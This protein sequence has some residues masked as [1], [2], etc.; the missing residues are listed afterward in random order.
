MKLWKRVVSILLVVLLLAGMMPSSL[1]VVKADDDYWDPS[2]INIPISLDGT[3]ETRGTAMADTLNY[4]NH[5]VVEWK[6]PNS[7]NELKKLLESTKDE[8]TYICLTKKIDKTWT[9]SMRDTVEITEDKV[10]DLNGYTIDLHVDTN[11]HHWSY[12]G[13]DQSPYHEDS[14]KWYMNTGFDITDGAS[15]YILDSSTRNS[16]NGK[17][18]TGK[19]YI[20]G[21]MLDPFKN[22][23]WYG[24]KDHEVNYYASFD[25]FSVSNGNLII[26]GGN[27][28]AGRSKANMESNWSWDKLK[29]VIGQAVELGSS[30]A[31]YA[32]GISASV[33]AKSDVIESFDKIKK[34]EEKEPKDT[35]NEKKEEKTKDPDNKETTKTIG[36]K[37]DGIDKKASS[38]PDHTQNSSANGEQKANENG[39]AKADKD[40]E[41]GKNTKIAEANKKITDS[42][43]NQEGISDIV[44]KTYDFVKGI[45]SMTGS[46]H[47]SLVIQT[48][49]GTCVRLGSMGTFVSYGGN[50]EGYG[51]SPNTRNAVVESNVNGSKAYIYGGTFK[52]CAGANVFNMVEAL[53][54]AGNGKV[55]QVEYDKNGN[56]TYKDV[57]I[58][59]SETM[60]L[61]EVKYKADGD[62]VDT[63]SILVRGGTFK[64]YYEAKNVGIRTASDKHFSM[65]AGTSGSVNLGLG[66]FGEDFI[67]DGRIQIDDIYGNGALVL[68]DENSGKD[69]DLYHYRLLC[70]DMELRYKQ[71]LRVY[72]NTAKTNSSNSFSLKTQYEDG[73]T[74]SLMKV[75]ADDE[76]NLRGAYSTTEKVFFYPINSS[77]SK[78]YTIRPYF[79]D[80][81]PEEDNLS[82]S[83][84]W[85]YPDPLDTEGDPIEPLTLTDSFISGTLKSSATADYMSNDP[86]VVT[87]SFNSSLNTT[88]SSFGGKTY[89]D[90]R[91]VRDT[92]AKN[93]NKVFDNYDIAFQSYQYVS[94]L[95]W[96]EYKVYKVDPLTRLNISAG[97][98]GDDQPL[99][100]GT[101]GADARTGLKTM[102]RLTDLEDQIK[103]HNPYWKGFKQGEM[104]RITLS[105]EERLNTD[106]DGYD[107]HYENTTRNNYDE[108]YF[109]NS[110]GTAK[111]NTSILFMCYGPEEQVVVEDHNTQLE[112]FTP[113]QWNSKN[114]PAGQ[115]AC[116]EFVNAK[117]GNVDYSPNTRIFDIYYQW[118][119]LDEDGEK[120]QLIAGT[121][122]VWDIRE[123]YAQAKEQN[124]NSE[125]TKALLNTGKQ[126]HTL[127]SWLRGKDGFQYA[128]TIAPW[129]TD[130]LEAVDRDGNKIDYGDDGLPVI[131]YTASGQ[132]SPGT[133]KWPADLDKASRLIH[134][135][136]TAWM[137]PDYLKLWKDNN[138][139]NQ[140]NNQDYGQYDYCY[141]PTD[142][143][144][145]QIIVEA[146]AVNVNWTDYYDAMQTFYSHPITVGA[147]VPPEE[148]LQ[149]ASTIVTF[150]EKGNYASLLNEAEISIGEMTDLIP[151]EYVKSVYFKAENEEGLKWATNSSGGIEFT[152]AE[153][154]QLPTVKFPTDFLGVTKGAYKSG[155]D[156]G[157]Y[158]FSALVTTNM[159]R[160]VWTTPKDARYEVEAER[161]LPVKDSYTFDIE[162]LKSGKYQS[163]D[164]QLFKVY[165]T[166][167][168]CGLYYDEATTTNEDVAYVDEKGMLGFGGSAGEATLS[169]TGLDGKTSNIQVTVIDYVDNVDISNINP[170]EIG[171]TLPTNVMIPENA[172]YHVERVYW[173]NGAGE[174]L[175]PSYKARNYK[176]Y[177][178]NI[179]I[180]KNDPILVFRDYDNWHYTSFHPYELHVNTVDGDGVTVT[181][182]YANAQFS[183]SENAVNGYYEVGDS[184]TYS[185]TY[186]DAI[187]GA[188]QIIDTV[189][190]DF[191]TEAEE[192][193]SVDTWMESFNTSTNGDDTEFT[194]D[195]G[196]AFTTF[197]KQTFEAY[198][199]NVD[200]EDPA[201]T[202]KSFVKGTIV[203]P[204]VTVDLD[205][206]GDNVSVAFEDD[207]DITVN[208]NGEPDEDA[209][210]FWRGDKI[211]RFEVPDGLTILEGQSIPVSPEYQVRD[212]NIVVD[213][214]LKLDDLLITDSDIIRLVCDTSQFDDEL[215]QYLEY[216]EN[217][218]VLTGVK[219]SGK[220]LNIPLYVIVDEDGDG[221]AEMRHNENRSKQIY[222]SKSACPELD[223]GYDINVDVTVLKPDGSIAYN[224]FVKAHKWNK[225]AQWAW[226][227][228]PEEAYTGAFI[229]DVKR[230]NRPDGAFS[231]NT[232]S[233]A[234][235]ISATLADG[236]TLTVYTTDA[237]E[238]SV[239]TSPTEIYP[240][241]EGVDDLCV[242]LDGDH[243][244]KSKVALT[245][246]TPDTEYLL[247]YR[248]GVTDTFYTK[249]VRTDP[250]GEE[251]GI[252]VGRKPVTPSNPGNL[253]R[254]HYHYDAKSNTLTIKDLTIEDMGVD[255]ADGE[256]ITEINGKTF[257]WYRYRAQSV[258]YAK[259]D[260]TIELQGDNFLNK[261]GGESEAFDS[262]N[263]FSEGSITFTGDGNITLEGAMY[264]IRPGDGKH[265]FLKGSGKQVITGACAYYT[266]DGGRVYY[267]NGD[268]DFNRG[269]ISSNIVRKEDDFVVTNAVHS[270]KY[271]A[272][273]NE[274]V[275]LSHA[276][277]TSDDY[278][279]IKEHYDGDYNSVDYMHVIPQHDFSK[280]VASE[281]YF[282]SESKDCTKGATYYKS[283]SC[284]AADTEHTF[285]V[286][287]TGKHE[288]IHHEGK[289]P[290]CIEE[291]YKAYD[292]CAKC[293]YTTFEALPAAG[294]SYIHHDEV[295]PTCETDGCPAYDICSVCGYTSLDRDIQASIGILPMADEDTVKREDLW[296]ATG[297]DLVYVP[298]VASTCTKN[299]T[300]DYYKCVTCGDIYADEFGLTPISNSDLVI[301]AGHSMTYVE[302][303]AATA[304]EAGNDEYYICDLCGKWFDDPD[305]KHEIKDHDSV[306][307]PAGETQTVKISKT[308][309]TLAVG[310]TLT[311]TAT[312]GKVKS[313]T[314]DDEKIATVTSEGKVTAVATGTAV[315]TAKFSGGRIASCKIT[316]VK[317]SAT[318]AT[319]KAGKTKTLKVTGATVKSWA[320]SKKTVATVTKSG[321]VTALT[322]GS[323]TITATLN[324]GTK[325][326][327]KITVSSNPTLKI[328]SK[329]YKSSTTYTVKKGKTLTV[330]IT[331]KASSVKNVYSTTKKTIA[332]V[333]SKATATKVKIKGLKKG[334]ATVTIK[335]NGKAFKIKVKVN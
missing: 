300:K 16:V 319:L 329:A 237:A 213:E 103:A 181:N 194:F 85:Y 170:P 111:A 328:G 86:S 262:Y 145:K 142:L 244:T 229:T 282:V 131:T 267:T 30:V 79:K 59:P 133:N 10:L 259:G 182:S 278:Q 141:I 179:E 238:V 70:S 310:K 290:T 195:K 129:D 69:G 163:G 168:S 220:A 152:V 37:Q 18:G 143:A 295:A 72:P 49:F 198:G 6:H 289:A 212:F 255:V 60:N 47:D 317:I 80:T 128:N 153:G 288:L 222:A 40:K 303:K 81:N 312:G 92:S 13:V 94:N 240:E 206:E 230:N 54:T 321:K 201:D 291:G 105:V 38:D 113:L 146:I 102:I 217:K 294:H 98:L 84:T 249:V 327:C 48:H 335:V 104:Y 144:G 205:P 178:I 95:K 306:I 35:K 124:L 110:L 263:I 51:S 17:T 27:F 101:Y 3:S 188:D 20:H 187:G 225:T 224:D 121:T 127:E 7:Y 76:E 58:H 96:L 162:D 331:G 286:A 199:Y 88:T 273:K 296:V 155:Y 24:G 311:L 140:N 308:A 126:Q 304:E 281:K 248:Q 45:F 147:P 89:A 254:D 118:W 125:E 302:A 265:V 166:N 192:G 276:Y 266:T 160:S 87:N 19:M 99:A 71:A 36:D 65:I 287:K 252:Y 318:K 275:E 326:T 46:N 169:F 135:Y 132:V 158:Q 270:L 186:F 4:K 5:G 246:L 313:W 334:S 307:I 82:T 221:K 234:G 297:H 26:Y 55:Q 250:E 301:K 268:I 12:A 332:K 197:A 298:A 44:S 180:K 191:L 130:L 8:D 185:Y 172:D 261:T 31:S 190:L 159:G 115:K 320:T 119:T 258:I 209:Q 243:W 196:F 322:K 274:D 236:D 11:V 107:Q 173:T 231:W 256:E 202:M 53:D 67:K 34:D 211:R 41:T 232:R 56:K 90:Y 207:K 73:D 167:Y 208:V 324:D 28:K 39:S 277:I 151:G 235:Q 154:D 23:Y 175:D 77:R 33:A 272:G 239:N 75:L 216:D 157:D 64:C 184:C 177:T 1:S 165:P 269:W 108:Y 223:N 271:M 292:T 139:S 245:G 114:V 161:A 156:A 112:D 218:N 284:G 299:G 66:S 138:L 219:A 164:I 22:A 97:M 63:S 251:Y 93:L 247:Y 279:V 32:T 260:I 226:F 100:T 171:K 293:D 52:A 136:S 149:G 74:E 257:L 21:Q 14:E 176:A 43:L 116:I 42:V 305:G 137:D 227:A 228:I 285:T 210:V 117:T 122:N 325:L 120:D 91:T 106:Y 214:D 215:L 330:T 150:G 204:Q 50:Y 233:H 15:F 200:M 148:K 242:S 189:N 316:V 78:G 333:T 309:A 174:E 83:P 29:T 109:S 2:D 193:G 203:G 315:I 323:A 61:M 280:E 134:A 68:M 9:N 253:E 25:L 283:C 241:F 183:Y 314:S 57:T 264:P 62:P 123:K